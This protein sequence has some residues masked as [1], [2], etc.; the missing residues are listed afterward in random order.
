M[1]RYGIVASIALMLVI[2]AFAAGC[3]EANKNPTATFTCPSSAKVNEPVTFDASN[4]KDPDG[5]IAKYEWNFGDGQKGTGKVVTHA[6]IAEATYTITLKVTDDKG[7]SAKKEL[8]ITVTKDTTPPSYL[9]K[10]VNELMANPGGFLGQKVRV[11]NVTVVENN[12]YKSDISSKAYV[13]VTDA[14]GGKAI[15]IFWDTNIARPAEIKINQKMHAQGTLDQYGSAY[16]IKVSTLEDVTLLEML[17]P[18]YI[19]VDET[20]FFSNVGNYEGKYVSLHNVTITSVAAKYNFTI[21]YGGTNVVVYVG[22]GA[23]G[24][25]NTPAVG[26]KVDVSGYVKF[27]NNAWQISVRNQTDDKVQVAT[28]STEYTTFPSIANLIENAVAYDGKRVKVENVIVVDEGKFYYNTNAYVWIADESGGPAM[29]IFWSSSSLKPATTL[30]TNHKVTVQGLLD[31]YQGIW[32][33]L[34]EKSNDVTVIDRI[35]PTYTETTITNLVSNV[36]ANQGKCFAIRNVEVISAGASYNYTVSDGTN[37]IK[38]YTNSGANGLTTTPTIGTKLNISGYFWNYK[39]TSVQIS[40]RGNSS[41]YVEIAGSA[42]PLTYTTVPNLNAL[43]SDTTTYNNTRVR[44]ENV[45]VAYIKSSSQMNVSDSSTSAELLIYMPSGSNVTPGLIV[46][47][48]V[49]VQ[50]LFCWYATG[51][52]WEIK[53]EVGTNDY[54]LRLNP[55]H[56]IVV[57]DITTLLSNAATYNNTYVKLENVTVHSFKVGSSSTI[58]Q[59]N[60]TDSSTST[61]FVI[62]ISLNA[63]CPQNIEVGGYISVQGFFKWYSTG[64]YFEI[65]VK[66]NGSDCVTIL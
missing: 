29:E 20:T 61:P 43:L 31:Q 11:E 26:D 25:A 16:E 45:T 39:G 40:V 47:D 3:T 60:V 37:S 10:T 34:P 6:F 9:S 5:K 65:E 62:Y 27:Y 41:D 8:T 54:V 22:Y 64:G 55:I 49:C 56:Y 50:G 57:A 48:Y 51:G 58:Q 12:G 52:Y 66:A 17:T 14:N 28:G 46:G 7:A 38:I 4:S 35:T 15:E 42:A 36:N 33:I 18:S 53:I 44:L 32:E 1:S 63:N 21:G 59:I 13:W 30:M 24:L 2:T 23:A 19:T